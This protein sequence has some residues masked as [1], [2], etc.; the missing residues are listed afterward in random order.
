LD[1]I[2]AEILTYIEKN[3]IDLI[4]VGTKEKT[5]TE[6]VLLGSVASYIVTHVQ[7]PVLVVR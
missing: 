2:S 5:G 4:V 6:R 1:S 7:C 3:E